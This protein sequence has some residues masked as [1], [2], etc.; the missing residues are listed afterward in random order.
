MTTDDIPMH[1]HTH[2]LLSEH[3]AGDLY[4]CLKFS[5]LCVICFVVTMCRHQPQRTID[6]SAAA[7]TAAES[8]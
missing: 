5:L 7:D 1:T 4:I 8:I 2:T 3:I 6:K